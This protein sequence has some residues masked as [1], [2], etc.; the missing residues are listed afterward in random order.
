MTPPA[1][2]GGFSGNSM[3]NSYRLRLKAHPGPVARCRMFSA[4]FRSRP[5]TRPQTLAVVNPLAEGLCDML[6]AART[7]LRRARWV[8]PD[9]RTA[10]LLPPS[11]KLHSPIVS[12]NSLFEC[13][14]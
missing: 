13:L 2:A 14:D 12:G 9:Q 6:A 7:A 1:K 5:R 3:S 4:A 8:H 10:Q 11:P